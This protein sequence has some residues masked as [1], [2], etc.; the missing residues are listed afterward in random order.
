VYTQSFYLLS[1]SLS[2]SSLWLGLT[3]IVQFLIS[4]FSGEVFSAFTVC[5]VS[6]SILSILSRA[7]YVLIRNDVASLLTPAPIFLGWSALI[8]GLG[9]LY[10][11][12]SPSHAERPDTSIF[13]VQLIDYNKV[14]LLNSIGLFVTIICFHFALSLQR[15]HFAASD[16]HKTLLP[17]PK[18]HTFSSDSLFLSPSKT[19]AIGY[20]LLFFS[21]FYTVSDL[22]YGNFLSG[23]G[24]LNLSSKI[25]ICGIFVLAYSANYTGR[26]HMVSACL[27]AILESIFGLSGGMRSEALLPFVAF[28]V[29]NYIANKSLRFLSISALALLLSLILVTPIAYQVRELTWSNNSSPN[30]FSSLTDVSLVDFRDHEETFYKVWSRLDYTPWEESMMS[31]FDAGDT[32]T[33][34]RYILWNFVPR[35]VYPEKPILAIGQEIGYRIQG[36]EQESSFAGT[37]YGEMYWNGGWISVIL[38][39]AIYGLILGLISRVNLWLFS[40]N[41][42]P[43][44]LI[45]LY[46]MIY[47]FTVDTHFSVDVIGQSVIYSTFALVYFLFYRPIRLL[48]TGTSRRL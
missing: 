20:G 18:L 30:R 5:F 45:G 10:Q 17:V 9:P 40:R 13:S 3:I 19:L 31:Q 44:L 35:I 46:G 41:T 2:R 28:I 36:I 37:V 21:L 33:T 32:G 6:L 26:V 47:G 22:L 42:W 38:S 1:K 48:F 29:G 8:F 34:Y 16:P 15:K 39:S 43:A 25:G 24:F 27:F 14:A 12:L 11:W 23:F 7:V 4:P